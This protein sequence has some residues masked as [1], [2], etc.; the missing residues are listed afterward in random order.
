MNSQF[1]D[2]KDVL[3]LEIHGHIVLRFISPFLGVH[4]R[5]PL[6]D[7]DVGASDEEGLRPED[8]ANP[9]WPPVEVLNDP[10]VLEIY[11]HIILCVIS[12]P[13]RVYLEAPMF[14]LDA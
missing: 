1:S 6:C 2:R 10:G 13:L 7:L 3:T 5:A 9:Q 8:L 14:D 4:L 11:G 12:D